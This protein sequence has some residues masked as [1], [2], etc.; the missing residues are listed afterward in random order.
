MR[1]TGGN[2]VAV[3]VVIRGKFSIV[4]EGEGVSLSSSTSEEG[5]MDA[6]VTKLDEAIESI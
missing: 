5:T 3:V 2:V 6:L 1:G 4:V